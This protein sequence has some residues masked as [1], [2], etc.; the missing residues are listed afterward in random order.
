VNKATEE[1]FV[2]N[3]QA[4]KQLEMIENALRDNTKV[5]ITEHGISPTLLLG[6]L[7][8]SAAGEKP[9]GREVSRQA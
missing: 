3:A 4:L 2:G 9:N 5:V 6:S 8:I 7:P 1:D